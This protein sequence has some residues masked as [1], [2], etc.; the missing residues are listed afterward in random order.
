MLGLI[1]LAVPVI[2]YNRFREADEAEQALLLRSVREEGRVLAQALAPLVSGSERPPL[3]QLGQSLARFAADLTNVKLLFSPVAGPGFYYV[4]SW[5]TVA[6]AQLDAERDELARE[7][8]L[9]RLAATSE[10]ELPFALRYPI[11]GGSDEVLTSVTPLKTPAGCWA[12]VTSFSAASLPGANL[13]RPYWQ[14]PEV[15]IAA[16][17]YY[18]MVLLTFSTFWSIRRGLKRFAERARA[19]RE[20]RPGGSFSAQNDVPELADVAEEF[21]RMVDVLAASARDLRRAAEDNAHAFKTPIAVIR[22]SLEPLK[23]SV[24]ADNQRGQRALGLIENSLDKLDG[25]V[26]SAR[27]LDEATADVLDT[28]RSAINL[29]SL[30]ARL[31]RTQADLLAQRRLELESQIRPNVLIYADE[32]MVE[33][34]VENLFDNAVSFSP[35]DEIIA[36]RLDVRD[37]MAELVLEDN[38]PGVAPEQLGRI[39]ERYF[40]QRPGTAPAGEDGAH[41]GIGLWVAR[42]NVEALGGTIAAANRQPQGLLMRVRLPLADAMRPDPKG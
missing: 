28:P 22:Q 24:G 17:V 10:G 4:A 41:F 23:R 26:A 39:F 13:G 15:R 1:F 33:T 37:G 34:V 6:A 12:V 32:E 29:S 30:L 20:R 40:S 9:D 27:Q 16:A 31:L 5:P 8:V 35:A 18:A 7:G 36:V 11:P 19:I 38:G 21:D 2:V 42:R 3:P 25:L 14:G